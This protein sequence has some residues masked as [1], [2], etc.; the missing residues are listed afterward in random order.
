MNAMQQATGKFQLQVG[1]YSKAV[2]GLNIATTQVLRELPALA[3]SPTTFAIAISN[4]IPILQDY[5]LK[6]RRAE[7]RLWSR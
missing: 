4:N 5:I 7:M 2:S 3:V 6:V 1:Q